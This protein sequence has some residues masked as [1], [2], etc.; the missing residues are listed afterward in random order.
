M[1]RRG[2]DRKGDEEA[3]ATGGTTER[4]VRR[5]G[6]GDSRGFSGL[7]E[8]LAPSVFAWAALRIHPRHHRYLDPEDLVHE[9]W[10]RALEAFPRFDPERA[11]FRTWIFSIATNALTDG[12][13]RIGVRDRTSDPRDPSAAPMPEDLVAEVT[14]ISRSAARDESLGRLVEAV[15]EL[16]DEDRGLFI[17]CGLEGAPLA[18]AAE[19]L[20]IGTEAAKKRWQRLRQRLRESPTWRSLFPS[21][22]E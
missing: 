3:S 17:L 22:D 6:Q 14:S 9:V 20:G 4:Q 2:E 5:A 1:N 19:L 8:R 18:S 15:R 7:Y 13:R 10:W 11:S 12:F 21:A 16:D